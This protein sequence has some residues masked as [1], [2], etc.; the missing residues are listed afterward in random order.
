MVVLLS[1]TQPQFQLEK[2]SFFKF[3]FHLHASGVLANIV[4]VLVVVT[5]S[6]NWY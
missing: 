3:V 1:V 4:V 6:S 2:S 5:S